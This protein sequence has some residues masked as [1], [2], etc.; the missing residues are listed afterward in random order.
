M[1]AAKKVAITKNGRQLL[2]EVNLEVRPGLFTAI[3]GP[4]GAGKTSLLKA[5]SG[6]SAYAGTL[7]I[8]GT[9]AHKYSVAELA[10]VRAVL[11]Q[12]THL[13]FPFTVQQVVKLSGNLKSIGE[14]MEL[15]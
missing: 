11:P 4:N 8:N 1:I 12:S 10:K 6:E 7:G 13:Q 9:A 2:K 15:T 3:A 5:I 14:V